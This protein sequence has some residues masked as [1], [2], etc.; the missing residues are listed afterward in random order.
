MNDVNS[1]IINKLDNIKYINRI[2]KNFTDIYI[3]LR[4]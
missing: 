4:I 3:T 1:T 2:S